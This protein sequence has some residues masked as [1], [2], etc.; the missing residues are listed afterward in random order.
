MA[1]FPVLKNVSSLLDHLL[2]K[3][4]IFALHGKKERG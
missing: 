1:S 2:E 3:F 4:F